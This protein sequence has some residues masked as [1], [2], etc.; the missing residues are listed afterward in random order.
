MQID[1]NEGFVDGELDGLPFD[2]SQEGIKITFNEDTGNIDIRVLGCIPMDDTIVCLD[3]LKN[4][5]D[6]SGNINIVIDSV[7]GFVNPVAILCGA[8]LKTKAKVHGTILNQAGSCAAWIA[9]CCDTIEIQPY[10]IFLLH[11]IYVEFVEGDTSSNQYTSSI[12]L[13]KNGMYALN[14]YL[15]GFL[16]Q[17]ETSAYEMGMDIYLEAEQIVKRWPAH[18]EQ[19][20]RIKNE[21]KS[22][23]LQ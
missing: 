5:E 2:E 20:V 18:K 15:A 14:T 21:Y 6:C 7:G 3:H 12:K 10:T 19:L 1:P 11:K 8:L 23:L 4:I 17:K 13:H 9:G 16:S 22:L